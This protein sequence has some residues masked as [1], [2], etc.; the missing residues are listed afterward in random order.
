MTTL[1]DVMLDVAEILGGV[2]TGVATGGTV[3]TLVDTSRI[4][5]ADYWKDGTLFL[6]SGKSLGLATKV[7]AFSENTFTVTAVDVAKTLATNDLYAVAPPIFPYDVMQIAIQ[8]ALDEIGNITTYDESLLVT[9]STN[10]YALPAGVSG[11]MR[12]E[13]AT[14][15]TAPYSYSPNYFWHENNGYLYFDPQKAP[16]TIGMKIRI[17]YRI[18]HVEVTTYSTVI[19]NNISLE[20]LKWKAVV[21]AYRDRLSQVSKDDPM[22]IDLLNQAM[23]KEREF[24]QQKHNSTTILNSFDPKF[25]RY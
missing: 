14:T 17:W 8:R 6:L 23:A 12:V 13:V 9:A 24:A 22:L 25:G 10:S 3:S 4:E 7:L 2:R 19:S 5:P 20:Y 16:S 18:P 21:N 15:T 11:L 1:A